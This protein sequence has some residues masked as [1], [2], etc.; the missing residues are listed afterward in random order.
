MAVKRDEKDVVKQLSTYADGIT[1][2]SFVQSVAFAF[3]VG[4]KPHLA[5]NLEK[6]RWWAYGAI[7]MAYLVYSVLIHPC[8]QSED[9]LTD[10]PENS[11][12]AKAITLVRAARYVIVALAAL[13][14]A[15][16]TY[17]TTPT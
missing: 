5:K 15:G 12:L 14:A 17:S 6:G 3:A 10:N 11:P 8:H 2:F 9:R 13:L 4:D 16:I 1:V 7:I